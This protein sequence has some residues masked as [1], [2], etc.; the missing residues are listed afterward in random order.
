MNIQQEGR[1]K[2]WRYEFQSGGT[3]DRWMGDGH[4][5]P[6]NETAPQQCINSSA[7][8]YRLNGGEWSPARSFNRAFYAQIQ[9]MRD[10]EPAACTWYRNMDTW[11]AEVLFFHIQ[12]QWLEIQFKFDWD[13][14]VGYK[15]IVEDD[16][17]DMIP[18]NFIITNEMLKDLYLNTKEQNEAL[19]K[20][21]CGEIQKELNRIY[22]GNKSICYL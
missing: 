3:I 18:S 21:C 19:L 10:I 22:N 11:S 2:F 6:N 17:C 14:K 13:E 9:A 15:V 5:D 4:D 16:H 7:T 12:E 8:W 20:Q 1:L